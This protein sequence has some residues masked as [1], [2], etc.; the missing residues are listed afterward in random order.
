MSKNPNELSKLW[1]NAVDWSYHSD[2]PHTYNGIH[3]DGHINML[4]NET[5]CYS[6]ADAF[7]SDV[8]TSVPFVDPEEIDGGIDMDVFDQMH[9]LWEVAELPFNEFL[10]L[11]TLTPRLCSERFCIPW[12]VMEDWMDGITA[13]PRYVRLM[14]AEAMCI[15]DIRSR[16]ATD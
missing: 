6:E 3:A 9:I 13:A 8:A 10:S 11:L 15:L 5:Y 4:Y 7:A 12:G 14:M 16:Y 2:R 1:K